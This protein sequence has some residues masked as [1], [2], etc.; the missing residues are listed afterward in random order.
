MKL[1]KAGII[2]LDNQNIFVIGGRDENLEPVNYVFKC[3]FNSNNN[4]N[5]WSK[6]PDMIY[7]RTPGN[8]CFFWKMKI[9]VFGG[10]ST[11]DF[12]KYDLNNNNWETIE[13]F[14]SI[15]KSSNVEKILSNY[16]C[17]LNHYRLFP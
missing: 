13:N 9:F 3:K 1:A 5:I 12:E 14:Y 17:V 16:S 11:N 2:N 15:I 10:S 7:P 8:A 4:K 6:A